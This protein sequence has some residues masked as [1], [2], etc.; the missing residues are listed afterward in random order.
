[1]E[2]HHIPVISTGHLTREVAEYLT[3]HGDDNPWCVCAPYQEGFFLYLE[4][5][6]AYDP[7]SVHSD[8]ASVVGRPPMPQCLI[9]IRDW[10]RKH[11]LPFIADGA[12]LGPACWVRLD[13]DADPTPDLPTYD[14]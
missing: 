8:L 6:E 11:D 14:W 3:A 7:E 5:L 12:R 13:S 4:E 9:D 10:M 2:I 1:M